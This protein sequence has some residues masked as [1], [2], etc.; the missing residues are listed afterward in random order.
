MTI[1]QAL[2]WGEARIRETLNQKA[3]SHH[4]PKL[5]AQVLLAFCLNKSNTYLFTHVEDTLAEDSV[6]KYERLIERRARHEPIAYITQK[7]SFY[8]RDFFVNSSVLIPR[9]ETEHLIDIA[10]PFCEDADVIVDVGTGSGTIAVT[11]AAELRKPVIAIDDSADALAVA[12]HNADVYGVKKLISFLQGNL[13]TPYLETNSNDS[14][15][16]YGVILANLPYEPLRVWQT[17][18]PDVIK[19][20]PKHAIVGGVDGLDLYDALLQQIKEGRDH[21]PKQIKLLM[22]INPS[23]ELQLPRLVK[24]HFPSAH[25]EVYYDLANKPRITAVQL[26]A[27]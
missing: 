3:F 25:V 10:K 15:K 20:E 24:E 4:H 12:R 6:Q 26:D 22:E 17:A 7:K 14:T 9:P 13:L 16:Q 11:I 19:Y 2:A 27:S 1:L 21:F 5:D 8:G 18:D 23:Q